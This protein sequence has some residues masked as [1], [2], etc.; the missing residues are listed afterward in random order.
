M[1]GTRFYSEQISN[2][3][4]LQEKQSIEQRQA[5]TQ[6]ITD[7]LQTERKRIITNHNNTVG[8]LQTRLNSVN[9]E[10]NALKSEIST[11]PTRRAEIE[12]RLAQLTDEKNTLNLNLSTENKNHQSNMVVLNNQ[13]K[14]Y[15][16]ELESIKKQDHNLLDNIATVNGTIYL[17]GVNIWEVVNLYLPGHWLGWILLIVAIVSYLIRNRRHQII[18]P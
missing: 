12:A 5:D 4:L 18:I 11:D 15:E 14:T 13:I 10:I 3:N 8:S 9:E 1:V 16:S 7:S 6:K 17:D 2:Q